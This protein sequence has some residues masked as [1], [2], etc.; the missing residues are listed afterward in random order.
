M[1]HVATARFKYP[2][3]IA[4]LASRSG[5]TSASSSAVTEG[6]AA[7]R[8]TSAFA[9]AEALAS[10]K[11]SLGASGAIYATVT[12]TAMAFPEAHVSLIFP[13]T[14]PIPIQYGVFG[15]MAL[16]LLGVIRGW[17]S[18]IFVRPDS[19]NS[20]PNDNC[21]LQNIRSLRALG[22]CCVW[23]VVLP[24]WSAR[25]GVVPRDDPGRPAAV[26]SQGVADRFPGIQLYALIS[27]QSHH[28]RGCHDLPK[29]G[30]L[31]EDE[32]RPASDH[33]ICLTVTQASQRLISQ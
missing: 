13:P 2:Q 7:A 5:S 33:N 15:F 24:V 12:L 9:G 32:T 17:R 28:S 11:P 23:S 31:R 20:K 30:S 10:I 29:A 8:S 22:W 16:D 21:I 6:A 4:Q 19:R 3:Y 18:V 25:L 27:T 14:P 26:P 1:S